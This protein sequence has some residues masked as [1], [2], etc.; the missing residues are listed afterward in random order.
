MRILLLVIL[1]LSI[2]H[3]SNKEQQ[4]ISCENLIKIDSLSFFKNKQT[5]LEFVQKPELKKEN[6]EIKIH[7]L[8]Q[9]FKD[10]LTEEH[11]KEYSII[12]KLNEWN[13][14]IGQDHI[15]NYY[16]LINKNKIDTLVGSP[17]VFG[18]T[19]LS[20]EDEYTD[21]QEIIEIWNIQDDGKIILNQRFS[22]KECYDFRIM[23]SYLFENYLFIKTGV[24]NRKSRF[25]KIKFK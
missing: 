22:L 9:S 7:H 1:S 5:P 6:N 21:F 14:I 15:Q 16:Y 18:K 23:D 17:K 2:F 4:N 8:N 13:L 11:F 10:N 19:L 20:I 3:C 25:Y 24:E 12:G